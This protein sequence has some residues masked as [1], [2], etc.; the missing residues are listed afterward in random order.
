MHAMDTPS[1]GIGV[2]LSHGFTGSP[3]AVE[4][5]A[6]ALRAEGFT[7]VT[8]LLPGH[9]TN[10]ED[11]ANRSWHE[12]YDAY[13][14]AY[15][16]LARECSSVVAAGLSMGGTLA[17]RLAS[18][19]PVAGVTVV[20]PALVV[21]DPRSHV[22]GVLRRALRTVP[23]ILNDIKRP[24]QDENAYLRVPVAAGHELKLLTRDTFLSLPRATAPLQVFR[25][26]VDHVVTSG[27]SLAAIV[28][29]Y[30]GTDIR[31]VRLPN[32]YHVA[33]LDYDAG[34]IFAESAAF[35]RGLGQGAPGRA[36]A[37]SEA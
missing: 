15:H 30:G 7:V 26:T 17:L 33:T 2:V 28:R 20:N 36:D 4:P 12:W 32:S 19:Q 5:W 1:P 3:T 27:R 11:L 21:D 6:E 25:S 10:W 35:I 24:G 18:R 14:E 13:E 8:P 37:R 34:T 31:I 29:L 22:S 16:G 9:G 23:G